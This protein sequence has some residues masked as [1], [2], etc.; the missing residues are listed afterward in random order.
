MD[1]IQ[2]V[3]VGAGVV[4]IAVARNLVRA[5]HEVLLLETEIGSRSTRPRAIR[6]LSTLVFITHLDLGVPSCA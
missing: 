3:V 1:E 2:T 5:G 4:G 6:R